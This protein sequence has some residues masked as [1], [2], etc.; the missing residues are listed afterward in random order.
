M[1][2]FTKLAVDIFDPLTGGGQPRGADMPECRT[3]GTEVES[4][5]VGLPSV[6]VDNTV[7]RFDGAAGAM[8]GSGVTIGDTNIITAASFISASNSLLDDTAVA[9]VTPTTAGLLAFSMNLSPS[10]LNIFGLICYRSMG[11]AV[12]PVTIAL[13]NATNVEY[14]TGVLTGVTGTDGKLTLSCNADGMIY[15][16]NRLGG[17]KVMTFTFIA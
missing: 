5:L 6:S 11:A 7:P 16:E 4:G 17:T 14:A 3:W 2:T 8:Q 13:N 15:V 1:T 9:L 12:A 10:A